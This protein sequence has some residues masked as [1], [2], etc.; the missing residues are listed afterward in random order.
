M[1]RSLKY[2]PMALIAKNAHLLKQVPRF[3]NFASIWQTLIAPDFITKRVEGKLSNDCL[4]RLNK[5]L[6]PF[7]I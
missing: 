2:A 3:Q 1:N 6:L 5:C 4:V 7:S